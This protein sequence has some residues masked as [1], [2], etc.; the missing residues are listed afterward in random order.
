MP[1]EITLPNY[2]EVSLKMFNEQAFLNNLD[3][4]DIHF[5]IEIQD[6]ELDLDFFSHKQA[7]QK[8]DKIP[9]LPIIYQPC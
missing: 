9:G 2:Y 5:T 7:K 3:D 8:I 4:S 1:E 6:I